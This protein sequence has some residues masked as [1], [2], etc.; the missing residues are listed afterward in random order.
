MTGKDWSGHFWLCRP[1]FTLTISK[2]ITFALNLWARCIILR[3]RPYPPTDHAWHCLTS[4]IGEHVK[5]QDH[6][7]DPPWTFKYCVPKFSNKIQVVKVSMQLKGWAKV[8]SWAQWPWFFINVFH[9][10]ENF[11][12][13]SWLNPRMLFHSAISSS[14]VNISLSYFKVVFFDPR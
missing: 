11:V 14:C 10:E 7:G 2:K 5:P 4:V 9:K 1:N 12:F 8:H 6:E 3:R 13:A